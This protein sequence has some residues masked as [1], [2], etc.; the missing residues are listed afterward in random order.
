LEA[1]PALRFYKEL[2]IRLSS[3]HINSLNLESSPYTLGTLPLNRNKLYS[4]LTFK[5]LT[6]LKSNSKSTRVT[7][8]S[9]DSSLILIVEAGTKSL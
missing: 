1:F 7:S 9:T 2:V 4:I 5:P 6:F 8:F 3:K